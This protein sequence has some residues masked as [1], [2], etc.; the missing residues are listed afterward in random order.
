V[1]G[2]SVGWSYDRRRRRQIGWA[3]TETALSLDSRF[4]LVL[5]RSATSLV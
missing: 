2:G 1:V 3:S 5:Q 4:F